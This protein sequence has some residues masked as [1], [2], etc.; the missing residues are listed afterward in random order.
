MAGEEVRYAQLRF[1]LAVA[2][3]DAAL[4]RAMIDEAARTEHEVIAPLL[5]F[6]NWGIPLPHHWTT[7]TNGAQFG[8]D[9]FTR[10]A[11]GKSNILVNR[12]NEAKYFYQDLDASGARLDSQRKYAVTFAPGQLP[13][14]DGFWSLTLYNEEHFFA[15]NPIKRFSIGTKN[16]DLRS[17]ADGSLTICVQTDEPRDTVQRANWLPAPRNGSFSLYLRAY[18]A[19][20]AALDGTWTPPAVHPAA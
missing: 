16:R 20:P 5:Q 13:P 19:K 7:Q 17:G 11:V 8:T 18:W 6:R 15:E 10:T 2:R 14:V 3:E 9:Y 1:M 4:K 12:P